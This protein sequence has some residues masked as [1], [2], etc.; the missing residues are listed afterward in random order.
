M[1]IRSWLHAIYDLYE[2]ES[3]RAWLTMLV[4]GVN[5][6]IIITRSEMPEHSRKIYPIWQELKDRRVF[7]AVTVYVAVVFGL[8]ELIDIIS[9]PLNFPGWVLTIFIF[10][11]AIGFPI[12]IIVSWIFFV[13]PE[14]LQ[15]YKHQRFNFGPD[16]QHD[17]KSVQTEQFTDYSFA[18]GLIVFDNY[19]P[20]GAASVSSD[21]RKGRIYGFSSFT[22][23]AV[24]IV[25][26]LFYS[27]KSVHFDERD[28]VVIADFVNHTEE[29][30]FDHTLN[31]AFE[32]SIDQSRHI[33]I[34]QKKRMQEALKR[35]GK[36][37]S[38][39]IDEGLC[40]EI[41]QREGAS[42][43][44]VPE[45]S[46]IGEKYILTS[47]LQET[48]TGS[49]FRSEVL[50]VKDQSEIVEKLDKLS[51]KMRR[52]LGESR[53]KISGQDKPLVKVTTSSLD[54]LKQY[55]LA[56]EYH[57][58]M[59]FENA[60]SHYENAIRIDS[61]FTAAKASLGNILFEKFDRE[62]GKVW[63]DEAIQSIDD[64][65]NREKYGI[66][67]FYAANIENDLD[68]S[69]EYTRMIIELYPD[70]AIYRSN[71][72]WYF[73]NQGHYE[74]AVK[75]Y[76]GAIRLEP[77]FMMP[78][79][80]L[81]WVYLD[82]M[83]NMDS[84]FIWSE[85]MIKI[86]PENPWGYYYLGSAYVGM[87]EF[88]KANEAYSKARDLNPNL[89]QNQYRLAYTYRRL[90]MPEKAIEILKEILQIN[91]NENFSF[92]VL[93]IY[94]QLTGEAE[95]SRE[96]YLKYRSIAEFWEKEY[97]D[98][99][100]TYVV[101]GRILT[102][103]GEKD[104]G[105]EIGKKALELDSTFHVRHAELLAVQDKKEEALD[106]LELALENGYRDL[107]WIIL[108]P[109]LFELQ[110]EDRFDELINRYFN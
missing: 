25:S 17:D 49:V 110:K 52:H 99:P 94:Y 23:I 79:G 104:A 101:L 92:Y 83:G 60:A 55:S 53:Y 34:I 39:F 20:Y 82:Y 72:G 46:K 43:Y 108:N 59:D 26:F 51:R 63:L 87:D 31:T 44:I 78:Y 73:Q 89:L 100:D 41:A 67:A 74:K 66:L 107:C 36:E 61:S 56:I 76:K 68:K 70:N 69:I 86:G 40:R 47:K 33:N 8:L 77:Y 45:I 106:H 81:L 57:R 2:Y 64:L 13:T 93:G 96:Y 28:W 102:R 42:V 98:M 62:K 18:D 32:I 15:R 80:G 29:V 103:L 105:W 71:L 109:D 10:L 27:G 14:G 35:M 30:I 54:A 7:R 75:E 38:E 95:L 22:I 6:L 24:V 88:E 90:G 16:T 19:S 11:S 97:P 4:F 5:L 37:E 91:P 1:R 50:Y 3:N 48:I 58:N 21:K 65:T 9:G 12:V 85:K 84:V